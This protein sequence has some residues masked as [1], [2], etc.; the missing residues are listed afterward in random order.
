LNRSLVS[1]RR[2]VFDIVN[3]YRSQAAARRAADISAA[4]I[5]VI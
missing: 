2:P 5:C 4:K 1:R 3:F